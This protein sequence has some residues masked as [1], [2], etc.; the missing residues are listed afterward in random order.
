MEGL[1]NLAENPDGYPVL[2]GI[3]GDSESIGDPRTRADQ[4]Q[5]LCNIHV[6]MPAKLV[7]DQPAEPEPLL[8][9]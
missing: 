7:F 6:L 4:N 8:P 2:D 1:G 3:P 5:S 9:L